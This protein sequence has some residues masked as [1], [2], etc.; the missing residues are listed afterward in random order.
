MDDVLKSDHITAAQVTVA[1]YD[2][3][4]VRTRGSV[5]LLPGKCYVIDLSSS[6]DLHWRRTDNTND[7]DDRATMIPIVA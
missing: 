1:C 4:G 3:L 2:R 6:G 7:F 5:V